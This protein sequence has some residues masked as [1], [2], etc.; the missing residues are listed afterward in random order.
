MGLLMYFGIYFFLSWELFVEDLFF[1]LVR[2]IVIEF[3]GD[4]VNKQ[5]IIGE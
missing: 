2:F 3:S 5:E 1:V 4:L